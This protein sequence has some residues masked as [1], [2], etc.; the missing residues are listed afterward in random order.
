MSSTTMNWA[1]TITASARPLRRFSLAVIEEGV[2]CCSQ[3]SL[4]N[5]T[6]AHTNA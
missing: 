4:M 6:I 3:E 5:T 2:I 1:A